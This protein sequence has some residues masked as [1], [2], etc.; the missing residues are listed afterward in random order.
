MTNHRNFFPDGSPCITFARTAR[1][2]FDLFLSEY[3]DHIGYF[4]YIKNL[5]KCTLDCYHKTHNG[6]K[7]ISIP[8]ENI[9][10]K[11][12]QSIQWWTRVSC[13]G[14]RRQGIPIVAI[15]A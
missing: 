1:K 8:F 2:K 9:R 5:D 10:Q 14:S 4:A 6:M 12:T 13:M 3:A 7:Q 15:T 11:D